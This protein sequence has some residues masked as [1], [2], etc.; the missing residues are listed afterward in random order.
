M[1]MGDVD[2]AN[3]EWL[4]EAPAQEGQINAAPLDDGSQSR[5]AE[6][7][8]GVIPS[9]AAPYPAGTLTRAM[10]QRAAESERVAGVREFGAL[11]GSCR[12]RV[13]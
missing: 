9:G 3:H 7:T 1:V 8:L 12:G 10:R 2:L 13:G 4:D 5:A 11:F 6:S